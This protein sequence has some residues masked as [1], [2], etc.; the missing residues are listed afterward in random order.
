MDIVIKWD[1]S[2]YTVRQSIVAEQY[3]YN[4]LRSDQ[5]VDYIADIISTMAW[6]KNQNEYFDKTFIRKYLMNI[7]RQDF[8]LL[9]DEL[10]IQ[11]KEYVDQCFVEQ[12]FGKN[13]TL[14]IT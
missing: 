10:N 8:D 3:R 1:N 5:I 4:L 2:R 14:K 9:S 12:M 6:D 11:I 7:S 13:V